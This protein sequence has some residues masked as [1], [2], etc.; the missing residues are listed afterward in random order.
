M[1][2]PTIVERVQGARDD[3]R[4]LGLLDLH[5]LRRPAQLDRRDVLTPRPPA[6]SRTPRHYKNPE[7]G[8][9]ARQ[10]RCSRPTRPTAPSSTRRRPHR[11]RRR[12]GAVDLQHQVVRA[13]LEE[14]Q[15][16]RLL[17]DRHAQEMRT[18]YYDNYDLPKLRGRV[19]PA[20]ASRP[21]STHSKLKA[22]GTSPG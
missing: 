2:W 11:R 5:L 6:P 20:L 14:A 17:P 15:G 16:H 13:L 12:A 18:A 10:G 9:P 4:H 19:I 21:T 3:A 8:R 7:G 1:P 22:P